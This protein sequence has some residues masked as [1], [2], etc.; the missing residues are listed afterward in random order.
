MCLRF[1]MFKL[2]KA[3]KDYDPAAKS[4]LEILLLY[5]GVKAT[6]LHRCAHQLYIWGIPFFPRAI[7]EFARFLTGIDIHPGAK[8]GDCVMIDHG[9]G[10]VIGETAIV[11]ENVLIYQGVTLGGTKLSHGKRHPTIENGVVVGAGAKVLGDIT[12]GEG[13]RIGS[14]SVVVANIPPHSTVVGIPGKIINKGVH[15]GEELNHDQIT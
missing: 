4:Y 13:T 8:L 2:L 5:P 6:C 9:M 10:V 11:G 15:P 3:Y 12:I 14:N 1:F 7:N